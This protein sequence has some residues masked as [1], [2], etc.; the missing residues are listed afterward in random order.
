MNRTYRNWV[1]AERLVTF[2]VNEKETDLLVSAVRNLKER[3]AASAM[4]YRKEIENH[5]RKSR[6][7]LNSLSP[8]DIEEENPPIIRDMIF[9][10]HKAGVG[11]MAAVA[12][13]IAQYVGEDLLSES[14][15]VIVENGGD[16]F[17]KAE[18]KRVVAIYAGDSTFTERIALEIQPDETPLGI[19]TS[20]GTVGHSLSFGKADAV[21]IYSPSAILADAVAT[22][23]CNLVKNH[24]DIEKAIDFARSIDGV[25]GIVIIF[26]EKL[27]IWG[28]VKIVPRELSA[29]SVQTL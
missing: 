23:A 27:G 8:I 22:A 12:G 3:A 17:I 14:G 10:S 11:P 5:I 20:S 4:H 1:G 26:G 29:P 6:K 7:F 21:A 15:E 16:I 9:E 13:A 2:N 18:S 24:S 28:R 19:C 25:R